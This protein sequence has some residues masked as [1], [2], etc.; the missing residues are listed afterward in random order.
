MNRIEFMK[1]LE[2]LLQSISEEERKD[3]LCY[4]EDYFEDAGPQKEQDVIRELGSPEHVARTILEELNTGLARQQEHS[5]GQQGAEDFQK[6]SYGQQGAERYQ[7]GNSRQQGAGNFQQDNYGQQGAA[8]FQ[9]GHNSGQ[10]GNENTPY[11]QYTSGSSYNSKGTEWNTIAIVILIVTLPITVPVVL[12]ILSTVLSVFI[13]VL[14]CILAFFV[15]GV[16]CLVQGVVTAAAGN[17]AWSILLFGI[18]MVLF[19]LAFVLIPFVVWICATAIP[20]IYRF[21]RD[22][23]KKLMRK[24]GSVL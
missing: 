24:G 21:T 11:G 3:A 12:S 8:G 4:Y 10:S 7:Q 15:A 18:G 17:A 14:A 9:T 6:S 5:Y 22:N 20:A 1:Q 13:G 16:V 23:V 2:V 19:A